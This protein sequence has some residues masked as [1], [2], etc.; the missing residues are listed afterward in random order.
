MR[1]KLEGNGLWESSRMMLP[2]HHEQI[3]EANR[4][5]DPRKPPALDEQEMEQISDALYRSWEERLPVRLYMYDPYEEP[6][7][8]GVIDQ[9]DT[10]HWRVR[11]D[12]CWF[13]LRKLVRLEGP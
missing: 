8:E 11:V 1:K 2:E 7:V 4:K 10:I 9:V 5:Q 3:R 12:G 13:D 6:V